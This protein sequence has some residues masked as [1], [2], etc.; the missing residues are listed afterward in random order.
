MSQSTEEIQ[1]AIFGVE[2]SE[3]ESTEMAD[4]YP[5][6]VDD[7]LALNIDVTSEDATGFRYS[8]GYRHALGVTMGESSYADVAKLVNK[9]P[10]KFAKKFDSEF[11]ATLV[12]L[13]LKRRPKSILVTQQR[14]PS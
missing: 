9:P 7:M 4:K 8:S 6:A 2:L 1:I 10:S 13:G 3:S 14:L 12:G 5:G 11:G